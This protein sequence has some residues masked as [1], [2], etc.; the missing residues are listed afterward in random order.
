MLSIL[1]CGLCG[2]DDGYKVDED[3]IED[4]VALSETARS[5]K[6]SVSGLH[7]SGAGQI[8]ADQCILQ[9][10]SYWEV[11][12]GQLGAGAFAVGVAAP[13]HSLGDEVSEDGS[14]GASWVLHSR[15]LT[16]PLEDGDVVGV[17]MD[18]GDYP[19]RLLFYLNGVVVRDVRGPVAEATPIISLEGP[20]PGVAL[21]ANFG[22]RPFQHKPKSQGFEGLLRS[23]SLI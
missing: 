1:C 11:T 14:S 18:Q 22:Q 19:V 5:G 4:A 16:A 7:V 2:G 12:V 10:K 3:V 23:R 6:I 21:T 13:A 20:S 8:M 17:A 9:D 15:S